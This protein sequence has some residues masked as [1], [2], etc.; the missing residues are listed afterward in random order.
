MKRINVTLV[1]PSKVLSAYKNDSEYQAWINSCIAQGVWGAEG[2]Y[3]VEV[4][5][6]TAELEAKRLANQG[7]SKTEFDSHA[8]NL[9]NPHQVTKVQ[10]GLENVPDVD[11][12]FRS[13]HQGTQLASTISDFTTAVQDVTIAADKISSG[14]VSNAEFDTLNNITTGVSIQSQINGKQATGNYITA[15][16]G[17]VSASGPG[18]ATATLANSG[19]VAGTYSLVTVDAK[20]RVT[21]GSNTGSVT[22]YSYTTTQTATNSNQTYTTVAELTTVSLPVGMYM[23]R[24][25]GRMQSGSGTNGSGVRIAAG[26]A[27][28]TTANAKWFVSH[29]VNSSGSAQAQDVNYTWDQLDTTTNITSGAPPA[30]NTTFNVW[31]TGLFRV[32][33]A[34]TVAIQIRSE[35]N[36]T[37]SS[38]LADSAFIMELV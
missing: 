14:V 10:I 37:A 33:V 4:I 32:T 22:R 20:G 21:V 7:A 24:F 38:L 30:A 12:T 16:T 35:L 25:F 15:L 8:N 36:G 23:F 3:S 13:S 27:T 6:A 18:S 11:A 34:G 2:N 29:N 28:L 31:G 9:D 1:S 19:V 17:D 26:T 5:D